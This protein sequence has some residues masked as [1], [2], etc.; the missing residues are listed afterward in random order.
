MKSKISVWSALDVIDDIILTNRIKEYYALKQKLSITPVGE[1]R[2]VTDA[3]REL[4]DRI[5]SQTSATRTAKNR[6][7]MYSKE[8]VAKSVKDEHERQLSL[9]NAMAKYYDR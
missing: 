8:G 3:I 5:L 1:L 7:E 6:E 9:R 4:E 2:D